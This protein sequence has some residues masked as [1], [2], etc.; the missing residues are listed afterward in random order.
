MDASKL[1]K[2]RAEA[3]NIYRSNWQPRDASEVT[4][5]CWAGPGAADGTG[6]G[7]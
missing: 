4:N 2:M 6:K 5:P 7:A 3:M 1:T